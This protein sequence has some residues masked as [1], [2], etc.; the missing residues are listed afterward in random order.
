MEDI[1]KHND[2]GRTIDYDNSDVYSLGILLWEIAYK[3][4][5]FEDVDLQLLE[6]IMN[7]GPQNILS[8]DDSNVNNE[9]DLPG[10]YISLFK[11]CWVDPI[12]RRPIDNIVQDLESILRQLEGS[13]S[14][15]DWDWIKCMENNIRNNTKGKLLS[16][17]CLIFFS[18]T[19]ILFLFRSGNFY[20]TGKIRS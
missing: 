1:D 7:E 6:R 12:Q 8:M 2:I 13:N 4:R 20:R 19:Y 9:Q 10:D 17:G 5:A 16:K 11:S 15:W 14:N 18:I 3:K